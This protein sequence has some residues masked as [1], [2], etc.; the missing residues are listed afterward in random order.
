MMTTSISSKAFEKK[1]RKLNN[2]RKYIAQNIISGKTDKVSY[3][4]D[5]YLIYYNFSKTVL[6]FISQPVKQTDKIFIE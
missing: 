2:E 3:W 5:V 4:A 6:S 1:T